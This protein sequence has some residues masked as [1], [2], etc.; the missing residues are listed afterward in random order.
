MQLSAQ[1]HRIHLGF[2]PTGADKPKPVA[3]AYEVR[4]AVVFECRHIAEHTGN[5]T[6]PLED[7]PVQKSWKRGGRKLPPLSC[8]SG[9]RPGDLITAW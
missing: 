1:R 5:I 4:E 8:R 6:S 9:K 7:N 3:I 2:M